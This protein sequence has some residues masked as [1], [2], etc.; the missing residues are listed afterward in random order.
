MDIA[1]SILP[2]VILSCVEETEHERGGNSV[3]KQVVKGIE[4]PVTPEFSGVLLK[5]VNWKHNL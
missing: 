4:V 3:S 1:A 2:S 5:G